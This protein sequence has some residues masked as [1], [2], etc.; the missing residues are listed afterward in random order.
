MIRQIRHKERTM[1][2]YIEMEANVKV[3]FE[4]EIAEGKR[5]MKKEPANQENEEQE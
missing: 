5:E 4:T 3:S 2:K 1:A